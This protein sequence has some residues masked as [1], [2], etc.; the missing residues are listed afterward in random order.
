VL[1]GPSPE[2]VLAGYAA[3][4]LVAVVVVL[5]GLTFSAR[6]RSPDRGTLRAALH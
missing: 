5:P 6:M 3:A 4:Q 1:Y 2:W